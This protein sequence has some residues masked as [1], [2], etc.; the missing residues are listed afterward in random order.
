MTLRT[1]TW[2]NNPVQDMFCSAIPITHNK[3]AAVR[4]FLFGRLVVVFGV[5]VFGV[6]F[7]P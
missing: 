1:V 6:V 7:A 3:L 5:V 2:D 4:M